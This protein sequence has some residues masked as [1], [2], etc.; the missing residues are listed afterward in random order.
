[1]C[2]IWTQTRCYG[3]ECE[4]YD[5]VRDSSEVP[6]QISHALTVWLTFLKNPVWICFIKTRHIHMHHDLSLIIQ[7]SKA[8]NVHLEFLDKQS[9]RV[10]RASLLN[11]G[12]LSETLNETLRF[13]LVHLFSHACISSVFRWVFTHLLLSTS[14]L[15]SD[16]SVFMTLRSTSVESQLIC[17]AGFHGSNC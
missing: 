4:F 9:S 1:M 8:E 3:G 14:V 15:H 16:A 10:C 5:V 13:H 7:W 2:Q 17:F 6:R 12:K 11:A